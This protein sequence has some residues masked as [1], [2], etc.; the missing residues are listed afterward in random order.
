[1]QQC[2]HCLVLCHQV[3]YWD[4]TASKPAQVIEMVKAYT[5]HKTQPDIAEQ[6]TVNM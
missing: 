1:M 6:A 4:T 3:Q 5:G 2:T